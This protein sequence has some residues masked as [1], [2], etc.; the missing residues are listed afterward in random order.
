MF[1]VPTTVTFV[2]TS[3]GILGSERATTKVLFD[4]YTT[5]GWL[6]TATVTKLVAIATLLR[7]QVQLLFQ[8]GQL[9]LYLTRFLE[10]PNN[11]TQ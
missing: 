6:V 3:R 10:G 2:P 9:K 5:T 1:P 11:K 8:T 7:H 4:L